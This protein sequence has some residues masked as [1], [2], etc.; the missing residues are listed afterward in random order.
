MKITNEQLKQIIKE[1]LENV[2][3]E[4]PLDETRF[5]ADGPAEIFY[6]KLVDLIMQNMDL[7]PDPA[8]LAEIV[9]MSA[10]RASD[11][12]ATAPERMFGKAKGQP[13]KGSVIVDDPMMETK[14]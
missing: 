11:L 14:K 12:Y 8:S 1:E 2:L 9:K 13:S 7:F 4:Q 3:E 10:E 5:G 6:K